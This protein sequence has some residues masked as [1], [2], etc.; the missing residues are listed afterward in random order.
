MT[1]VVQLV[2]PAFHTAPAYEYTL[3]PVVSEFCAGVGYRPDPE[4][5]LGLNDIFAETVDELPVM[6]SYAVIGPRRNIKT[7]LEI[8]TA[9]G[10][11]YVLEVPSVHYSAHKWKTAEETFDIFGEIIR[12]SDDLSRQMLPSSRGTGYA[13]LRWKTGQVMTFTTR[14][15]DGGR[16]Q[17]TDK[18]ILDE[19][20]KLRPAHVGALLPAL[21][22]RPLAQVLYGSSAGQAMSQVLRDVR[23]RGRRGDDPLLGYLE[24]GAPLAGD[25]L[26][27]GELVC[28]LGWECTHRRGTPGCGMDK[29]KVLQIAN[30][31]YGRR[32]APRFFVQMRGEM[33]PEEFGREFLTWWDEPPVKAED[34]PAFD[35]QAWNELERGEDDPITSTPVSSFGIEMDLD[36]AF[37]VIGGAGAFDHPESGLACTYVEHLGTFRAGR[38]TT[39]R[40]CVELNETFGPAVFV[41]AGDGPAKALIPDLEEAGLDVIT[42]GASDVMEACSDLVDG[43]ADELVFHGPQSELKEAAEAARKRRIGERGFVL[44]RKAE[45]EALPMLAVALAK[46]GIDRGSAVSVF[47]AGDLDDDDEGTGAAPD[48]EDEWV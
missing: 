6:P 44:S 11:L 35:E 42:A 12:N 1:A 40:R 39:I 4:Q 46:W 16:G 29:P 3:G 17:Q 2:E 24:F 33:P 22:T 20:L 14:T 23:D 8:Q 37:T 5:G 48:P 32:I 45:D 21:A 34:L 10:W 7:G 36:R 31:Q 43:I 19:A 27:D 47:F 28:D 26:E 41:I 15:L 18:H 30:S 13:Q 38:R 25:Q 9:M